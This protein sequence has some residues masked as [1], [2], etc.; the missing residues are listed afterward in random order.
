MNM[1]LLSQ[2]KG[3]TDIWN[4]YA[5]KKDYL[6][7]SSRFDGNSHDNVLTPKVSK[8]LIN[9]GYNVTYPGG[10]K[11]A[12]C[13]THDVDDIYPPLTHKIL[14]SLCCLKKLNLREL[15][16]N[17]FWDMQGKQ[18]SPYINFKKIIEL[19]KKY[20]AKSTFYFMTTA[21]DPIR[22]RYNIEDIASELA[23]ILENGW[24]VGL[25][26]GY[27]A[28]DEMQAVKSEKNRL[29][30][31]LGKEIVGY[32]NHYLRFKVPN[33]WMILEKCGFKYDTTYGY[34]NMVGFRNGMCHPFKPFNLNIGKQMDI[35][36]IP[37]H[38]MDGTLFDVTKSFN[39]AWEIARMLIDTTEKYNGVLTILWHN[40]V[41]S[42]PFRDKWKTLY[43]K[44][45]E[46]GSK[47]R[48]WMT[49]GEEIMRWWIKNG[50]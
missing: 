49:S 46:Y 9:E 30:R 1:H 44:I 22:F 4:I 45:L 25:H 37:L 11:F 48:A 40:N 31:V 32:R 2:L 12:L 27:F 28:Y 5:N 7:T 50:Y 29:E 18:F 10:K 15:K 43:E 3:C 16:N 42:F 20:N 41:F 34:T 38:I 26:G 33:T 14:A 47:K 6:T 35:Y 39:K 21:E 36:E 17:L 13:L 24:E 23:H 8:Y 19:E